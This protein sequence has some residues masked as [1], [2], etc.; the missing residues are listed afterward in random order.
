ML[1]QM[2]SRYPATW[3]GQTA[4]DVRLTA[5]T[6]CK[7]QTSSMFDRQFVRGKLRY[8][9]VYLGLLHADLLPRRGRL[10]DLGCGRG[11]LLALLR[12]AAELF[13]S[14]EWKSPTPAPP[15]ELDL[16]GVELHPAH[17]AIARRALSD[18]ANI[19]GADLSAYQP[20]SCAAVTMFDVLHYLNPDAQG[21]LIER[22]ARALQPGGVLLIR[23]ADAAA[24]FRHAATRLGEG[25]AAIGRGRWRQPFHYR[26]LTDWADLLEAHGLAVTSRPMAKGT[27]FSNVLIEA[28]KT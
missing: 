17:A 1:T 28:R 7:Y 20:R 6:A 3:L 10:L 9:P 16:Q 8:D 19:E 26:C 27:P 2:H 18:G 21:D 13:E 25:A 4:F 23:E 12:T 22:T 11:I 14:N 5:A 24:G 15:S